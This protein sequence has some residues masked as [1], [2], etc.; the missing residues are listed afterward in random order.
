MSGVSTNSI[1]PASPQIMR[2]GASCI[3]FVLI[4]IP[5]FTFVFASLEFGHALLVVQ[6]VEEAARLGCRTASLDGATVNEVNTVI[7]EAMDTFGISTHRTVVQ[8]SNL[9]TVPQWE[10]ITVTVSVKFSDVCLLPVPRYLGGKSYM[11]S[12][13]LPRE[14]TPN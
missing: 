7:D 10:P 4:A 2:R 14:A 6:S 1:K 5:L 8:P 11:A 12:C 3:E 13:S 9:S